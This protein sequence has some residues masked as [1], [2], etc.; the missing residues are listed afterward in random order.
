MTFIDVNKKIKNVFIN[1]KISSIFKNFIMKTLLLL[2][3]VACFNNC[4]LIILGPVGIS[5][6]LLPLVIKE[7]TCTEYTVRGVVGCTIRLY[8]L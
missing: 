4:F 7:T 8:Y 5:C 6:Q 3:C 1:L 2:T